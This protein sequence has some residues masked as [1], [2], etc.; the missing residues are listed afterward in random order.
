MHRL[1]GAV[2]VSVVTMCA[3]SCGGDSAGDTTSS[4]H[5]EV[6]RASTTVSTAPSLTKAKFVAH[7]NSLCRRKWPFILHAFREYR[8][9]V[10]LVNPQASFR[11]RFIEAIRLAYFASITFH[12]FDEVVRLGAPSGEKQA[13][14]EMLGSMQEGVERG[15][16]QKPVTSQSQVEALFVDYNEKAR[17]YGLDECLVTGSHLPHGTSQPKSRRVK[18]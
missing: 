14:E 15:Q 16:R 4:H 3:A 2:A 1:V 11:Q 12:I 17:R 18:G 13:V 9:Q 8:G 6:V 10:K 7:V 5:Q